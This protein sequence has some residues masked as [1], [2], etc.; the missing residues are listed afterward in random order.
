ML[1][2]ASARRPKNAGHWQPLLYLACLACEPASPRLPPLHRPPGP[3]CLRDARRRT[4]LRT[5]HVRLGPASL[6]GRGSAS[7][8]HGE[9]QIAPPSHPICFHRL[10]VCLSACL[11]PSLPIDAPTY[12]EGV[13]D[14]AAQAVADMH[15]LIKSTTTIYGKIP[16]ALRVA[17]PSSLP[18]SDPCLPIVR[19]EL[20]PSHQLNNPAWLPR[21]C[22]RRPPSLAG[23]AN[24]I[25]RV[26]WAALR[27]E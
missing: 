27:A 5:R 20:P 3:S 21:L 12:V 25:V 14:R 1:P 6:P 16:D 9:P 19:L 11:P 2:T 24:T 18:P 17:V 4:C 10:P 8:C 23:P 22:T 15:S 26:P 7:R 13:P